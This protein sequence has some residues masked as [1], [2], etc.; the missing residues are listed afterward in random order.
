MDELF[1]TRDSPKRRFIASI[2]LIKDANEEKSNIGYFEKAE[3]SRVIIQ[4]LAYRKKTVFPVHISL[5]F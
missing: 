4:L 5:N 2:S 3:L 1:C